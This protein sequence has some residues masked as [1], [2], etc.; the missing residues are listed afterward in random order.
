ML[1]SSRLAPRSCRRRHRLPHLAPPSAGDVLLRW[2]GRRRWRLHLPRSGRSPELPQ[3]VHRALQRRH[4]ACPYRRSTL[5]AARTCVRTMTSKS[6]SASTCGGRRVGQ[7]PPRVALFDD[8][9]VWG[10]G[11]WRESGGRLGGHSRRPCCECVCF[12]ASLTCLVLIAFVCI[13][14]AGRCVW[15]LFACN[16]RFASLLCTVCVHRGTFAVVHRAVHRETG[17]VV[18]IKA[19]D[20]M[21]LDTETRV[22]YAARGVSGRGTTS[23]LARCSCGCACLF[24][25][26][27]HSR[28]VVP[29]ALRCVLTVRFVA[30]VAAFCGVALLSL[31]LRA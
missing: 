14:S 7:P 28:C 19:V 3:R 29:P 30:W 24:R 1:R 4:P 9:R 27:V 20:K 17:E 12:G 5:G 11:S 15:A 18:A 16:L 26:L 21:L 2:G 13:A 31:A 6:P 22:R 23:A 25:L 10:V 8:W